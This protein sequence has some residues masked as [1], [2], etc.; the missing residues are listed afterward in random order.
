MHQ[1][2]G[3]S[4]QLLG[5]NV[6]NIGAYPFLNAGLDCVSNEGKESKKVGPAGPLTHQLS[7]WLELFSQNCNSSEVPKETFQVCFIVC[8]DTIQGA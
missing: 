6:W 2:V 4:V 8:T 5:V 7:K 1:N 3:F